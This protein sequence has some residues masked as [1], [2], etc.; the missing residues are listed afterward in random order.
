MIPL[1]KRIFDVTVAGGILLVASPL[2]AAIALAILIRDGRPVLFR[3]KRPGF[4]GKEFTLYKFR[5]MSSARDATGTLLPDDIRLTAFGKALRASSLDELPQ[6]WNVLRGDMS[7]VGPRPLMIEYLDRYSPEQAR[8]HEV[9]PGI[10]GWAQINGRNAITWEKKFEMDVWYVDHWSASLD[11]K[12]LAR[13]I[14]QVL[15]RQGISE[16]G[17]ATASEF[18]GERKQLTPDSSH[19]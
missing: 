15:R 3:D 16:N 14:S 8:R 2:L 19:Q 5:S 17:Y 12:I 13:T 7:L 1:I 6:L 10:T 18:Q 9:L 11:L 4:E